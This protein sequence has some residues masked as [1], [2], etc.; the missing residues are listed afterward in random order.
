[1]EKDN[2]N[3][4]P[5]S[6]VDEVFEFLEGAG[7]TAVQVV[8]VSFKEQEDDTRLAIFIKGERET[9]SV[10]MAELVTTINELFALQEQQ[11]AADNERSPI[12]TS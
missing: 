11:E 8:P 4:S 12:I 1:M 10:I 5:H 3:L 9:A 2:E 6:S 7:D